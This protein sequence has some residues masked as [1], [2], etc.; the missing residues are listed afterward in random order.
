MANVLQTFGVDKELGRL[1]E[2]ADDLEEI[3]LSIAYDEKF[4]DLPYIRQNQA[5]V[6]REYG[7]L[8]EAL[9]EGTSD[10]GKSRL[11]RGVSCVLDAYDGLQGLLFLKDNG[12]NGNPSKDDLDRV[13]EDAQDLLYENL[14]FPE[15]MDKQ[16]SREVA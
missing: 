8:F 5:W 6:Q 7:A 14:I 2:L 1:Q 4:A 15:D 11:I 3:L 12:V 10:L 16:D 13:R 9:H